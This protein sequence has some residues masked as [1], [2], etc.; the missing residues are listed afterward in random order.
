MEA[1]VL[2]PLHYIYMIGVLVVLGTMIGRKDTVL[3]CIIFTFI[4]GCVAH[5]GN[6]IKGL[7]ACYNAWLFSGSEFFGIIATIAAIVAMS[8]AMADIGADYL[9]I[10]P[11]AKLMKTPDAAF[12]ILG[13]SMAIMAL[14]IWPSPAVALIGGIMTPIAVRAGLPPIGSAI[15]MNIFGHGV[16][17]SMDF[18]I[19][20][21]PG[22]TGAAAGIDPGSIVSRGLPVFIT[23]SVIAVVL[24]YLSL[25]RDMIANREQ[26]EAEK[27]AAL[28]NDD[29]EREFDWKA[30]FMAAFIPFSFL[31]AVILMVVFEIRGG[32][33]TALISGVAIAL[34]S[35]SAVLKY[36]IIECLEKIPDYIRDGFGFGMK[37]FAPVVVIA[38]FFFIGGVGMNTILGG[39][40]GQGVLMDW[41]WWLSQQVPLNKYPVAAIMMIVACVVGLDGSGFAPLPLVG[42]MAATFGQA[43]NLDPAIL[44]AVGQI[45]A[46]WV[47]GATIVPWGVI[48]VAAMC[49][50]DPV[51]LSRRNLIPV[52][53]GLVGAVIASFFIL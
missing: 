47:G 48:P 36:G 29:T 26:Y 1:I 49:G 10:N 27:Q 3:P 31:M 37:I 19:Q 42:A 18:I 52:V 33:A 44:S 11:V 43:I 50:V 40:F 35:I 34:M 51:E 13:I 24:S 2:T 14:F 6:V 22:V 38:G 32:D 39:E 12:F 53:T 5:G 17:F 30:R 41:G 23:T 25:K 28:A 4:M 20:G 21:A 45:G 7:Q 15:A 8:K 9:M 46:I 16:A